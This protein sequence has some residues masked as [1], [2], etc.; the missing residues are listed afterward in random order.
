MSGFNFGTTAKPVSTQS[1][2]KAWNI[3]NNVEFDGISDPTE[4]TSSSGR[5]WRRWDM[6]FKCKEGI[7][8]E[9][10]FEPT[11]A[12]A[13][14]RTEIATSNGGTMKL[15]S[16]I[17]R[18]NLIFQQVISVYM[19]DTNKAKFQSLAESGKFNNIEFSKFITV[20]KK[21]LENPKK[22][23]EDY[24]IMLKLQGRKRNDR[25][26]ASLPNARISTKDDSAWMERFLGPNLTL[27]DYERKQASQT[28]NS[29]PTDMDKID[30]PA[31]STKDDIDDLTD[32]LDNMDL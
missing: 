18:L 6:T 9:S 1:F 10:I 14:E 27:S 22:P 30:K 2:L 12:K 17:E 24:P 21:Y 7:Y 8:S 5:K 29:T 31:E 3:Y 23:T 25:V 28:V 13:S 15:P 26:Y 4:G 20:L 11:D 19:N 32:A 16:D